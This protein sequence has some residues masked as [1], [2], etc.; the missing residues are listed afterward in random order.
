MMVK[1]I[2][3]ISKA[4]FPIFKQ[5]I[6]GQQIAI[7]VAGTGFFINQEGVFVTTAHVFDENSSSI[8]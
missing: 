4:M 6:E 5:I 7:G 3:K 1:A 8:K 2:G